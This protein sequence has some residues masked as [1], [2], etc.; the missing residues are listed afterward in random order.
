MVGRRLS[1]RTMLRLAG[2]LGAT[3]VLTAC[4]GGAATVTPAST[5]APP[6]ATSSAV[7]A[8]A[9]R[10][11]APTSAGATSASGSPAA[12]PVSN[13]NVIQ[14]VDSGAQLPTGTV[15]FRWLDNGGAKAN[16][17]KAYVQKYHQAHPNITIDYQALPTPDMSQAVTLGVQNGNAPDVLQLPTN[18]TASQAVREGWFAA[19]DDVIPNFATWKAALPPRTLQ[20]GTNVFAGKTYSFPVNGT[21]KE[22]FTLTYYNPTYLHAAGY[23][24]ATRALTWDEFRAAAKKVTAAGKGQYYGYLIGGK[25]TS[26]WENIVRNFA[27][28]AGAS[29]RGDLDWRTGQYIY[30]SDQYRAVIDLLLGLKADGSVFPGSLSLATQDAASRMPTGVTGLFLDGP[31]NIAI[32][33]DQNPDFQFNIGDQPVPNDGQ[34]HPITY[35]PNG[36]TFW[37]YAKSKYLAI[38]GDI[39]AYLGSE[40]GML[41]FQQLSGAPRSCIYPS[42]DQATMID[43]RSRRVFK[44]YDQQMRLGPEPAVRNPDVSLVYQEQRALKPSFGEV[45]LGIYSGQLQD[46]KAAMQDLQDRAEAELDRA[47]KAAQ[48]KGAKVSRDDW[49]FA[50]WDPTKDYTD[51]DYKAAG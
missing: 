5:T 7:T 39:F 11:A 33:R 28:M 31:W 51:A 6:G 17:F 18:V 49:K 1:R 2:G 30:T 34:R 42:V 3:A 22:Y 27:A 26:A 32:W 10:P 23:D 15:T 46:A 8:A 19:L 48:G 41:A 24:P 16:F 43:E 35:G 13:A 47:I 20:E 14:I 25:Q 12:S 45:V 29:N 9:T 4:G 38:G 40:P 50:N 44:L 21:A 36:G 37:L